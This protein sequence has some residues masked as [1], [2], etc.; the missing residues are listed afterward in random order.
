MRIHFVYQ[1]TGKST[2]CN[3]RASVNRS[4]QDLLRIEDDG[5]SPGQWQVYESDPIEVQL[6]YDPLFTLK[7]GCDADTPHE[8]AS[9]SRQ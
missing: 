5:N 6:T 4:S 3:I 2:G 7:M 8:P 1:F 9:S